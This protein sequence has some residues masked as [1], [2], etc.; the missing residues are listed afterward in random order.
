MSSDTHDNRRRSISLLSTVLFHAVIV[1]ALLLIYLRFPG[2]EDNERTWP[3]VDSSEV[4]F[5][6][7]YVMIGDSPEL[8][9]NSSD[10]APAEAE[11][12]SAV[13]PEVES[14][15]NSGEP[16]P[17]APVITSNRPSPAK[18]EPKPAP[19]KTGPTKA[20]REAAEKAKREQERSAA[21]SNRVKFDKQGAGGTGAGNAGQPD[22]NSTVGAVRGTPGYNMKG[23]TLAKWE[24]PRGPLGEIT[25]NVTVNRQGRVIKA[26]YGSGKGAAASDRTARQSCISAAL[27][28]QFSVN[29]DAPA[30]QKGTITYSFE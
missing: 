10:L 20:E 29:N 17:P 18:A 2:S 30:Q 23:R 13:S 14:L 21:I 4:L 24:N 25:V 11:A 5:G 9:D 7:E 12:E 16:A 27:R 3:P 8:A 19:E 26:E 1:V 28:S 15:E 6:G 22:G